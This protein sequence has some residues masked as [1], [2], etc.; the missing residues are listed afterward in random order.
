LSNDIHTLYSSSLNID[1]ADGETDC[2]QVGGNQH[3]IWH[4]E[5]SALAGRTLPWH[6]LS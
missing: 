4:P 5:R 1:K 3:E 2:D 6:G